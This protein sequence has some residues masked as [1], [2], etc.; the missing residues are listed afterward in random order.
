MKRFAATVPVLLVV[1]LAFASA[2][3]TQPTPKVARVGWLCTPSCDGS[4]E[5]VF[6][7]ELRKLGWIEGA[8]VIERKDPDCHL[9]RLPALAADVVRSKPNLIVAF[10]PLPCARCKGRDLGDTNC[11]A[12]RRRSSRYGTCVKPRPSWRKPD[13]CRH[14]RS[15]QFHGEGAWYSS[16]GFA[17]GEAR[18]SFHQSIERDASAAISGEHHLRPLSSVFS[19]TFSRCAK[20]GKCLA[21]LPPPKPGV[22]RPWRY[23]LTQSLPSRRTGC[24]ILRHRQAYHRS[25]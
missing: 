6:L 18:G 22:R 9:D 16:R 24:P 20:R 8:I 25:P 15:G 3:A 14:V 17:T 23:W 2:A 5:D 11:D 10:T 7:D 12:L 13:W 19:S 4:Y 1:L 21:P